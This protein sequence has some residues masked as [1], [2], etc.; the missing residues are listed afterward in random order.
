MPAS[1]WRT[2]R[3]VGV[4]AGFPIRGGGVDGRRASRVPAT[5]QRD[6]HPHAHTN[7]AKRDVWMEQAPKRVIFGPLPKTSTGKVQKYQLR[8]Q[9]KAAGHHDHHGGKKKR[10]PQEEPTGA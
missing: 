3:R 9:A 4:S 5:P 10:G 1:I 8:N 6:P 7:Y 2:T